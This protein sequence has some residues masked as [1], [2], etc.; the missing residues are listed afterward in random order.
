MKLVT[1]NTQACRGVDKRVDP[2]RIVQVARQLADFDVLC[3]QEIAVN[4]PGLDGGLAQDQPALLARQLPGWQL[5]FG[6]AVDEFDATGAPRRFGN[7][8]ATRLPVSQVRHHP[9]PAPADPSAA[10]TPR[11]CT[12]LTLRHPRLG[13]LRVMTTHLEYYSRAQRVAQAHALRELHAAYCAEAAAPPKPAEEGEPTH[14]AEHTPHAVLC[15]DFNFQVQDAEFAALTRPFDGGAWR[16]A[17][18]L[19]HGDAPRAP[20]FCVHDHTYGPEPIACDFVFVSDA[21]AGR[22]RQMRVDV[23]TQASDHQPV[24]VELD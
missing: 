7:L 13:P 16:D 14:G 12:V 2:A 6:P 9:L 11:S 8:V 10:S 18:R 3:L 5:F 24:L 23:E 20:T 21:L 19:V 17:W 1:W 22:V 4:C 15:G